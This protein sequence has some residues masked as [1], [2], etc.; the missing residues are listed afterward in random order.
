MKTVCDVCDQRI[1]TNG[2]LKGT[3]AFGYVIHTDDEPHISAA[4]ESTREGFMCFDCQR[5]VLRF[6]DDLSARE[7]RSRNEYCPF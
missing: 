4:C 1:E 7:R 2:A 3:H 6:M 5:H